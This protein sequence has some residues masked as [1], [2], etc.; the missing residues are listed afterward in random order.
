MQG[1]DTVLLEWVGPHKPVVTVISWTCPRWLVCTVSSVST[2]ALKHNIDDW[3]HLF[4]HLVGICIVLSAYLFQYHW[5]SVL[6]ACCH[7]YLQSSL[8]F[9]FVNQGNKLSMKV[10]LL[11][12]LT[13]VCDWCTRSARYLTLCDGLTSCRDS[14]IRLCKH[15]SPSVVQCSTATLAHVL[16]WSVSWP[17]WHSDRLSYRFVN[18]C[19]A[20][21]MSARTS[22]SF[23]P[24]AFQQSSNRT[25]FVLSEYWH[26]VG[27]SRF[28]FCGF[29]SFVLFLRWLPVWQS[30]VLFFWR[31]RSHRCCIWCLLKC[32]L[33]KFLFC[34]LEVWE[35][36]CEVAIDTSQWVCHNNSSLFF[37][38][39]TGS[40]SKFS[41]EQVFI[42]K[43]C[44]ISKFHNSQFLS[45][46]I[47]YIFPHLLA[48]GFPV[49]EF[50]VYGKRPHGQEQQQQQQK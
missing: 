18:V 9:F 29:L 42:F 3:R 46:L 24:F 2:V 39:S 50:K 33:S 28:C 26:Y 31:S 48:T 19:S 40:E 21:H 23:V 41:W 17:L 1:T 44:G 10:F 12:Y 11:A 47:S 38:P 13:C 25:H 15:E 22:G 4:F 8:F 5:T 34:P 27:L 35:R 37:F 6:Q 30:A 16:L 43:C 7:T 20:S 32:P 45:K 36:C 49:P 14:A